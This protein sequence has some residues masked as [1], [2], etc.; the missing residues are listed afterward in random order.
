MMTEISKEHVPEDVIQLS[1]KVTIFDTKNPRSLINIVW[2][3]MRKSMHALLD[4]QPELLKLTERKLEKM[5]EPDPMLSRLRLR[6]W[7]EYARAQDRAKRMFLEEV[8][9]GVCSTDSWER[10]ISMDLPKI[11]WIILP[12]ASYVTTMEELLYKGLDRMREVLDF[13]LKDAKGTPNTKLISEVVKIVQ[14]LDQRVKGAIIQKVA[15]K[16]QIDQRTQLTTSID[17][18]SASSLTELQAVENEI[19]NLNRKLERW[20]AQDQKA[21]PLPEDEGVVI[22]VIGGSNERGA[23]LDSAETTEGAGVT[24]QAEEARDL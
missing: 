15:I 12:P 8:C 1:P 23:L 16:Q 14:M 22:D 4:T 20:A 3:D 2:A 13:P 11:A 7:D 6:F 9:R 24:S 5:V 17:P 18:L 19:Q 21:L 10:H